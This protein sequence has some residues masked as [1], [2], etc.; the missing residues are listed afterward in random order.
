MNTKL[1]IVPFV[2]VLSACSTTKEL[3]RDQVIG[4]ARDCLNVKMRP[5]VQY[6]AKRIDGAMITVPVNVNCIPVVATNNAR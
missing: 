6:K 1:L 5:D 2:V 3:S 4:A